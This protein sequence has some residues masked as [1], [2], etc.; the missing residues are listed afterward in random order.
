MGD[1]V[2]TPE[3]KVIL[4][5]EP[6]PQAAAP[7]EP[8]AESV[9]LE[10]EEKP[11]EGTPAPDAKEPEHTDEEKA[12]AEK[13]GLTVETD[14]KGKT[15][16]VDSD[17]ARIPPKRFKEI[18][19]QSKEAERGKAEAERKFK[20]F[21]KLGPDEYYQM[22]PEEAPEGYKPK[23]PAQPDSWPGMQPNMGEMV[24]RGGEYDGLTLNE[25]WQKNPA[26][27]NFLQN[28]HIES[29]RRT[30]TETQ[31]KK[32]ADVKSA[33]AEVDQFAASIAQDL[34]Q[35][36]EL[37]AL[38]KEE[39]GKISETIQKTID[40]MRETG[41]GGGVLADAYFLMN[42]ETL[43][44]DAKVK[45]GKA[46]MDSI[47]KPAIPSINTSGGGAVTGMAAYEGMS[48]DQLSE[49][50]ANMSEKETEKFLK[51]APQSLRQKHP[52]LPWA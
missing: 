8:P 30:Q 18:Y 11:P 23:E 43:L 39:E 48:R 28:Q 22:Y 7:V 27:A 47:T 46:A 49:V 19:W 13:M 2:F 9:K 16:F 45:G 41:R 1:E 5:E 33:T 14:A 31:Q 34:F 26:Y 52:D 37:T 29:A 12:A 17:G 10:G 25:V 21:Q 50:V 6:E 40:W 24:V 44:N 38:T 15:Y 4:G 35:K 3:E 36:K 51:S 20:L 32:E 42:K